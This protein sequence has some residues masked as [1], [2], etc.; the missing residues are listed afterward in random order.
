MF[1]IDDAIVGSLAGTALSSGLSFLGGSNS[2]KDAKKAAEAQMAFQRES[3]MNAHQWEVA[4]LR[5]AGLNPILSANG[6]APMASGA[7]YAPTNAL[8]GS[9]DALGKGS[10]NAVS[11]ANI[12]A[13]TAQKLANANLASTNAKATAQT[14]DLKTP[15]QIY[16]N[17]IAP[18]GKWAADKIGSVAKWGMGRADKNISD[19][20]DLY[21]NFQQGL[22]GTTNAVKDSALPIVTIRPRKVK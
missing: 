13:D 21:N 1:G 3:Q 2:N 9:A 17:T 16:S 4:D 11:I 10:A 22:P 20:Q 19:L 8:S 6:G 18:M 14:I 7:S 5:K 15:G 12:K